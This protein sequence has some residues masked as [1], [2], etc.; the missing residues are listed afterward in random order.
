MGIQSGRDK[1]IEHIFTY[2]NLLK[3]IIKEDVERYV[4][5]GRPRTKY[6]TQIWKNI[7]KRKYKTL[8]SKQITIEERGEVQL[9]NLRI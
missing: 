3:A 4:G 7:N 1:I 9:N 6:M 8:K 5:R 2:E